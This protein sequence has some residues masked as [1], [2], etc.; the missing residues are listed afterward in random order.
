MLYSRKKVLYS[1]EAANVLVEIKSVK[2][3]T[4][5]NTLNLIVDI[6]IPDS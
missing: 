4:K 2:N 5:Q 3:S 1:V 6:L